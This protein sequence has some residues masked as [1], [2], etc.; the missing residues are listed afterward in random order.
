MQIYDANK[1]SF[2]YRLAKN[3]PKT[4]LIQTMI[5]NGLTLKKFVLMMY[6]FLVF[7]RFVTV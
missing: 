1:I 5:S 3:D 7:K 2:V 6:I 4:L